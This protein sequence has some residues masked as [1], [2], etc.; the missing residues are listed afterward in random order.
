[1]G[2]LK[3]L[4]EVLTVVC[5]TFGK[6]LPT[7]VGQAGVLAEACLPVSL[8]SAATKMAG[9]KR[10]PGEPTARFCTLRRLLRTAA[11]QV[12]VRWVDHLSATPVSALMPTDGWRYSS[13]VRT[14]RSRTAGRPRR[15][16]VGVRLQP[17]QSPWLSA[18]AISVVGLQS[19]GLD[20]KGSLSISGMFRVGPCADRF[21]GTRLASN[22]CGGT[23]KR[24]APLSVALNLSKADGNHG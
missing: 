21:G 3:F 22:E 13:A 8:S 5:G 11:G 9:S 10:S 23:R 24:G 7:V 15:T 4:P 19:E 17:F 12:G 16:T 18:L 6:P 20:E 1:M 14:W 2:G